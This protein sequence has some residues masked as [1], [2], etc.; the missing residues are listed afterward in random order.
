M[1]MFDSGVTDE[2]R[3]WAETPSSSRITGPQQ[4]TWEVLPIMLTSSD[5][6]CHTS[7]INNKAERLGEG[8]L[9]GS[10]RRCRNTL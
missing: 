3:N 2:G 8:A 7:E 6:R 9:A 1:H 5:A 4:G 10:A